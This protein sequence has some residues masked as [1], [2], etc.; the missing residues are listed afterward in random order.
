MLPKSLLPKSTVPKLVLSKPTAPRAMLPRALREELPEYR[1][2]S[3]LAQ[4]KGL[5]I[6][7]GI[8]FIALAIWCLS[9]P[10]GS[11]YAPPPKQPIYVDTV[12]Q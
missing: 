1:P 2:P 3:I 4:H 7:F 12:V 10:R 8:L 9:T 6:A 5:A 11:R